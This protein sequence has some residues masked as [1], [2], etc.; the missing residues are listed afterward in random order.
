VVGVPVASR[1]QYH[2]GVLEPGLLCGVVHKQ[3]ACKYATL[4]LVIV[5]YEL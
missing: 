1:C 2:R 3:H 4:V 5:L